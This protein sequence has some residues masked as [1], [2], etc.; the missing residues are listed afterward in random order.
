MISVQTNKKVFEIAF[1]LTYNDLV[2]TFRIKKSVSLF[3]QHIETFRLS[4]IA[5]IN[6][7]LQEWVEEKV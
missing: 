5:A 6:Y 2:E 3:L 1:F 4:G 7:N